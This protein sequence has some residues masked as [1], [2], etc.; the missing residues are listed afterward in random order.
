M[1]WC[2]G[3]LDEHDAGH[4][5]AQARDVGADF[6]A[7]ELASFAGLRALRHFNFDFL[8]AG[9]IRGGDAEAPAGGICLMALFALVAVRQGVF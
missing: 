3:G 4:G 1:S 9:E 8:R 6:V 7:G 5:V 2:G